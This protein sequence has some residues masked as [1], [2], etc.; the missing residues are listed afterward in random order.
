MLILDFACKVKGY[1]LQCNGYAVRWQLVALC[2][3]TLHISGMPLCLTTQSKGMAG[4]SQSLCAFVEVFGVDLEVCGVLEKSSF[5]K[6]S[7]EFR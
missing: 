6:F 5:Y 2:V 7:T 4:K 3:L 1:S